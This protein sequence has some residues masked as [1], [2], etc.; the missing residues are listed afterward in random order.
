M[1]GMLQGGKETTYA[2]KE[3]RTMVCEGPVRF[4]SFSVKQQRHGET[5]VIDYVSNYVLVIVS[6]IG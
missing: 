1:R 2:E 6:L 5:Q 4:F 3:D